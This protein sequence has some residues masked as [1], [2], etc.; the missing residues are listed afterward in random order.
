[1]Y[2]YW[3]AYWWVGSHLERR[4]AAGS[5]VVNAVADM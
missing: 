1:M 5:Y 3:W 2:V 4:G